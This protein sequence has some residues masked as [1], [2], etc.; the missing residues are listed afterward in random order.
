MWQL[1]TWA[2]ELG[3]LKKTVKNMKNLAFI[4][5]IIG[6]MASCKHPVG[7]NADTA[8]LPN[9]PTAVFNGKDLKGWHADVPKMD[10]DTS[11]RSPFIVRNGVLEVLGKPVGVLISDASYQDYRLEVQ[12]RWTGKPGNSGILIHASTPRMVVGVFPK[13]IE[14][15]LQYGKAGDFSC[16]GVDIEVPDMEAR[17]GP[18]SQWGITVDKKFSIRKLT[19]NSEKAP[20][21]W[22][23]MV[24]ECLGDSIK[25]WLNNDL[26]NYGFH[27]SEQKGQIALQ[28]EGTALECRKIILS[29]ITQLDN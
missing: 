22:N 20:G 10:N 28:S 8:R 2:C 24:I 15:Q 3:S 29:S 11:L 4:W 5:L 7:K 21:E 9:K 1:I 25:V 16:T 12:Y 14:A 13:C 6:G 26:V 18:R 17:R 27:C 19:E 23:T